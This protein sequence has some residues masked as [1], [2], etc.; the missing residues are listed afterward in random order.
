M[1]SRLEMILSFAIVS[2]IGLPPRGGAMN[3]SG[4]FVPGSMRVSTHRFRG[5]T[6]R[7]FNA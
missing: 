4:T 7:I 5:G 6:A 3:Y 1:L 2:Q